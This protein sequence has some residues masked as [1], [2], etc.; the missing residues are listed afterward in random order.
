MLL[1]C[2][3]DSN[4]H[5]TTEQS[6]DSEWNEMVVTY[7]RVTCWNGQRKTTKKLS[8]LNIFQLQT[9]NLATSSTCSTAHKT[10][11]ML[12]NRRYGRKAPEFLNFTTKERLGLTGRKVRWA[13]KTV[14][15][16]W[17]LQSELSNPVCGSDCEDVSGKF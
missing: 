10:C 14:W 11:I 16:Q 2:D 3:N 9:S 13:P 5:Y 7:Y 4:S 8:A 6:R 15:T 17:R 12:A 1:I